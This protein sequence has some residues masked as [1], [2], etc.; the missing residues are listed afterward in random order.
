MDP[1]AR[2]RTVA[3][4]ERATEAVKRFV[5]L[6]VLIMMSLTVLFA[7]VDLART[8]VTDL[9]SPPLFRV[10][11]DELLG[12]FG[13]MLLVLVGIELFETVHGALDR[14][15]V[16]HARLVLVAALIATARG[17]LLMKAEDAGVGKLL[18]LAALLLALAV[19]LALLRP[20]R[21]QL[22]GPGG[23]RT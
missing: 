7:A 6:A 9:L 23:L 12:L 5:V 13:L 2:T 4:I 19:A 11:G 10:S 8:L 18:A 21:P 22:P 14:K 16:A 15:P 20:R 1:P 17:V 3:T